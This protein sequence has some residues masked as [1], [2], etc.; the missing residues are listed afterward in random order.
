MRSMEKRQL[1][2][3]ILLV[4][5]AF[6]AFAHAVIA[7]FLFPTGLEQVSALVGV[8]ALVLLFVVN[9]GR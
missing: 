9:V 1:G 8:V 7:L 5:L 2:V 4:A 3:S 6:A